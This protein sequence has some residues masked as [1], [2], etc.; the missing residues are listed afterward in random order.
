MTTLE[1]LLESKRHAYADAGFK[2]VF[3]PDKLF[4]FQAVAMG[5]KAIGCELK[6]SYYRQ[7]VKNCATAGQKREQ[8]DIPLFAGKEG[9]LV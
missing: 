3:M 7:A 2:P 9:V 8:E 4:P 5:R 6:P 1:T